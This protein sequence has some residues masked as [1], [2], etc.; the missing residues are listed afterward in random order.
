MKLDP[1]IDIEL[2]PEVYNPSDDSYLLLGAIEVKEGERFLE[3]G[4]GSGLIAVH[5]ALAGADVVAADIN[6]H[7][8]DCTRRNAMRN[9]AKMEVVQSDLFENI[10][11]LFDVIAFNPPY[12]AVEE[13]SSSWIEKS[14]SGGEDGAQIARPFI[15]QAIRHLAP[16]GRVYIILSSLGSLRTLLR[17]AKR[18]YRSTMI[19]EK[20]MFFESIFAYRLEPDIRTS[21]I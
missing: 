20:Q 16:N 10:R 8:V 11:G 6:P 14:W 1:S 2:L 3:I 18:Q 15:E 21:D 5:A 4:S 12:L 7:A 13:S 19:E 9:N 17:E